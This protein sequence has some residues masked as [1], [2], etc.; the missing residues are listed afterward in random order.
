[1]KVLQGLEEQKRVKKKVVNFL[2]EY[3]QRQIMK[4]RDRA[5]SSDQFGMDITHFAKRFMKPLNNKKESK[6]LE[7][8][9][10]FLRNLV[11]IPSHPKEGLLDVK[12]S[13]HYFHPPSKVVVDP[14]KHTRDFMGLG[15]SLQ[16][17]LIAQRTNEP[18][19]AFQLQINSPPALRVP[20]NFRKFYSGGPVDLEGEVF[21]VSVLLA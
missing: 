1:M 4:N 2:R 8:N 14:E 21:Q 11:H 10:T 16:D 3:Q 17:P 9:E 18:P 19:S 12:K 20:H 15:A 7:Q 6:K 5:S 13:R